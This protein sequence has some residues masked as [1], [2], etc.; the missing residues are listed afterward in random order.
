MFIFIFI[1]ISTHQQ[2]TLFLI[3]ISQRLISLKINLRFKKL[4]YISAPKISIS[5][6]REDPRLVART[7]EL[8]LIRTLLYCSYSVGRDFRNPVRHGNV[9]KIFLHVKTRRASY[10]QSHYFKSNF[11]RE[12]LTLPIISSSFTHLTITKM[13]HHPPLKSPLSKVQ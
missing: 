5:F 4:Y 12:I 9:F 7:P 2:L 1:F 11:C 3:N 8:L 10:F 6:S 13:L